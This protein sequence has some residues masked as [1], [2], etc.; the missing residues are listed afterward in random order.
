MNQE[1]ISHLSQN[2]SHIR[3]APWLTF[4]I[5]IALEQAPRVPLV[6]QLADSFKCCHQS[7]VLFKKQ[8]QLS[9]NIVVK[10]DAEV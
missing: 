10:R 9:Y 2:N 8:L 1:P 5:S 6:I 3:A 4:G 7:Q